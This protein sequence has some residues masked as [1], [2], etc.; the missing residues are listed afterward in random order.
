M[1]IITSGSFPKGLRP[2]LKDIFNLEYGARTK[3]YTD[4][5]DQVSSDKQY[6]ERMGMVGLGVGSVKAEGMPVKYSDMQQG[7]IRRTTNIM[8]A[9]GMQVTHEAIADNLYEQ[10]FDKA[11]ELGFGMYQAKEIQA[12][13]IFNNGYAASPTYLDGQP[14]FSTAHVRKGGGTYS[15]RLA[16]GIDLSE[17]ALET[18]YTNLMA[19]RNE[20]GLLAPL[21]IKALHLPPSL[22]HQGERLTKS[23][24]QAE[25]ANNAVNAIR[26]MGTVPKFTVQPFLTDSDAYFVTAD[27]GKGKGPIYQVR[28]ALEFDQDK[29]S[30]TFNAK[31][32]AYERYA[33]DVIDVRSVYGSPGL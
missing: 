18:I 30:D 28:E 23:S 24:Q 10:I 20:R 16:A 26:S 6:E 33:F 3:Y 1:A 4:I 7:Y 2:G 11:R 17:A 9:L 5:F 14:L 22:A 13:A 25:T 27:L 12:A 29:D 19:N 21:M 31:F 15:N 8:I 32:L